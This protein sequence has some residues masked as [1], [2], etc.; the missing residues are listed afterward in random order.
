MTTPYYLAAK[1][2]TQQAGKIAYGP[3]QQAIYETPCD[4]SA[5][6]F[7]VPQKKAWYIVIIGEKPSDDLHQ[8]LL[9]KLHGG[10]CVTTLPQGIIEK[11]AARRAQQKLYGSWVERHYR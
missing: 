5:Y 10:Q 1:Y 3:I 2:P 8:D 9:T 11:L 6:H 7:F 4:L